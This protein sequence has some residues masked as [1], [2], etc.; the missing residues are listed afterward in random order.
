MI[1]SVSGNFIEFKGH[2]LTQQ[3]TPR[4]IGVLACGVVVTVVNLSSIAFPFAL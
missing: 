4:L 2:V 3:T 1:L